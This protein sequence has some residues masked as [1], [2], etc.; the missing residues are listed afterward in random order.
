MSRENWDL[1]KKSTEDFVSLLNDN[2]WWWLGSHQL[3][4]WVVGDFMKG[5]FIS[6]K[7]SLKNKEIIQGSK[8]DK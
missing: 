1:G 2:V 7:T 4:F 5:F 8:V 3:G 6:N